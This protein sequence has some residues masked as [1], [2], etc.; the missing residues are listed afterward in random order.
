MCE[1][2]DKNTQNLEKKKKSFGTQS[3]VKMCFYFIF[4]IIFIKLIFNKKK[5]KI[6]KINSHV[7]KTKYDLIRFGPV[8]KKCYLRPNSVLS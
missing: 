5:L 4:Y 7:Q 3:K 8:R 6:K 2:I 1:D